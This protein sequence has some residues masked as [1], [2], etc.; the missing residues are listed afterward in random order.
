MYYW[1]IFPHSH[2]AGLQTIMK[3][4]KGKTFSWLTILPIL[5]CHY[6]FV[7]N[8]FIDGLALHYLRQLPSLPAKCDGCGSPLILQH[9]LWLQERRRACHFAP[10]WN[11]WLPWRY[12]SRVWP[13]V[14]REHIVQYDNKSL[15]DQGLR[16]DLGIRG[17]WQPQVEVFMSEAYSWDKS[18]SRPYIAIHVTNKLFF[19]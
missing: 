4:I 14:I 1:G 2:L 8:Q 19:K 15:H 17:V 5:S 13:Q 12:V 9:A 16:L 10:Q 7:P 11:L 6:D 3:I 18:K